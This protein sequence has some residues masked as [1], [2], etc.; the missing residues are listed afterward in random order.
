MTD[1][2]EESGLIPFVVG[3]QN[4]LLITGNGENILVD[5]RLL[6]QVLKTTSVYYDWIKYRISEYGFKI[7]EDYFLEKVQLNQKGRGTAVYHLTIDMAKELAMLER[8]E[9]GRS[10]RQYF[11]AAEKEAR[12]AYET[13]RMMPKGVKPLDVNGR[14]VYPFLMF[15]IKLGLKTGGS[16]YYRRKTYPNHFIKFDGKY[17]ISEEMAN[18]MVMQHSVKVHRANVIAMQPLLPFDFGEPILLMKGGRS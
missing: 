3:S 1:K 6:H 9:I 13:G 11:I 18:L 17:Y 5:A 14:K 16:M 15:A 4:E 10:F 2:K 8:S 7:N 12:R